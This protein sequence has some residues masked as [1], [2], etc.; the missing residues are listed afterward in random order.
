MRTRTLLFLFGVSVAVCLLAFAPL[1]LLTGE[2]LAK[3]GVSARAVEGS[4]WD[5]RLRGA[6]W[7][8]RELGD[9]RARLAPLELLFGRV[10]ARLQLSGTASGAGVIALGR[11]RIGLADADLTLP[12][13][14]IAP[15]A[16]LEGRIVLRDFTARFQKG[17]CRTARGE[18]RLEAVRLGDAPL[19][20]LALVGKAACEDGF[21]LLPMSGHAQGAKVDARLRLDG[22]GRYRLETRVVTNDAGLGLA[23]GLAGFERTLEGSRRTDEGRIASD[24][25][26]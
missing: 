15:R 7:Q 1:S 24:A 22:A 8:G 21:L 19:Q 3:A 14:L 25:G 9:V 10:G 16:P 4:I 18:A 20:G 6:A 17:R 12:S 13:R 11:D 2:G 23:L 5:G 26:L